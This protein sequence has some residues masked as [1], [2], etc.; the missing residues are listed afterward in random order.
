M[1]E[2]ILRVWV[3]PKV[4]VALAVTALVAPAA[5]AQTALP[6][7]SHSRPKGPRQLLDPL[8]KAP[9]ELPEVRFGVFRPFNGI[10]HFILA[11]LKTEKVRPKPLC[12]DFDFARRTSLDICGVIPNIEDLERFRRWKEPQRREMWIDLLLDSKQYADHWTIYWGDLIRERG[13]V[14]GMPENALKGYIHRSLLEEK[15]F[16]AIVREMIA[17]TGSGDTNP[18]TGFV[19][20]D[21]ADADTLT[22]SIGEV[23]MG[24]SI[25]CAQCHDHPFDWWTKQDFEGMAAFWRNTAARIAAAPDGGDDRPMRQTPVLEVLRTRREPRGAFL[26]GATSSLGAGPEALAELL[27]DRANPYFA[28]VIVN[29]IW[30]KMMGVGLV[31]PPSNFSPLNPPTHSE[32]LDWLALEFV[33]SGYDIKHIIRLIAT[34][35]T[36]Q[37]TSVE[38]KKRK[39][40][41]VQRGG[42]DEDD[43]V[44]GS[45]FES[46]ILRRMT[47]E[48]IHDSILA[49]TG[50]YSGAGAFRPA[51]DVT[52]PPGPRSFLRTFGASDRETVGSKPADG[53]I[54]QALTL[55]NGDFVNSAV[56]YHDNHPLRRWRSERGLTANQMIEALFYQVLTRAPTK[57][58]M[59]WAMSYVT[60]GDEGSWEDLQWA[61]FNTREFQFIR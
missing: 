7:F 16:D 41:L 58:E 44:N 11:R 48:Q 30:D 18:A 28:R 8:P 40:A 57:K 2:C 45:L 56:R 5:L 13:R 20:Q 50:R 33:S 25:R 17:A 46:A 35:R 59:D 51:I 19:L 23:F 61:L 3:T 14:F 37:Q 26:T 29:R 49:A 24:V 15:P 52:Y 9:P 12:D 60:G 47:A 21:R 42:E 55:L 1:P 54:Q 36:Y 34:S 31:N 10:D 32:L 27:T 53:S 39:I 43:P 38:P 6:D 22:I 4:L